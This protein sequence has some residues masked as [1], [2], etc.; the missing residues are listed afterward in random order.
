MA[1]GW[2]FLPKKHVD[3]DGKSRFSGRRAAKPTSAPPRSSS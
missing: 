3:G 2:K 1:G